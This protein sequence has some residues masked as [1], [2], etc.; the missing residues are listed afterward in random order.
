MSNSGV[1]V[2]RGVSLDGFSGPS[3][4]A[5]PL[6]GFWQGHGWNHEQSQ[7]V[8]PLADAPPPP[9]DPVAS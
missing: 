6:V 7:S 9:A 1:I 3:E 4:A 2:A 5:S 8:P